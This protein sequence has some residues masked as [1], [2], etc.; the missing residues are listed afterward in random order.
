MKKVDPNSEEFKT[1]LEKTVKFTDKI[2]KTFNWAYNPDQELN[3]G[4]QYGLTRNKLMHGKRFC[5]CFMVQLDGT[6]RVC[7]CPPAIEK[8]IPEDGVCHC[9]IFCTPEFA[10][11]RAKEMAEAAAAK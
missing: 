2:V 6:D 1:T 11:N 8:E 3:E 9:Q 4:I 10:E 5:P 7:P